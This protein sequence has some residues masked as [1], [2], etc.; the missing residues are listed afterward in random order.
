[1]ELYLIDLRIKIKG[2]ADFEFFLLIV[3]LERQT[4]TKISVNDDMGG[5][6]MEGTCVIIRN[7]SAHWSKI[8]YFGFSLSSAFDIFVVFCLFDSIKKTNYAIEM[9]DE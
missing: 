1:M 8:F 4:V 7:K 2:C 9:I 3:K 6:K 5:K